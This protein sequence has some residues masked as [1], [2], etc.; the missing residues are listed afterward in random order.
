MPLSPYVLA[1]PR[2][3]GKSAIKRICMCVC[4]YAIMH[5]YSH[6]NDLPDRQ[7]LFHFVDS[8]AS[9]LVFLDCLGHH[10][11]VTYLNATHL[12]NRCVNSSCFILLTVVLN[13][14]FAQT[15]SFP[16]FCAI[17]DIGF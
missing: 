15:L 10:F 9:L 2:S 17:F 6:F 16:L 4:V 8:S 13:I 7:Y 3:P 14:I 11:T 12:V 5:V 1:H